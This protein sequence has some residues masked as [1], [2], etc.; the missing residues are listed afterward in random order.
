MKP[1]PTYPVVVSSTD[2]P[3]WS[4]PY[5][6]RSVHDPFHV[7]P[8]FRLPVMPAEWDG[9]RQWLRLAEHRDGSDVLV[10]FG[11]KILTVEDCLP[12]AP[13]QWLRDNILHYFTSTMK[14]TFK[15]KSPGSVFFSSFFLT[16]LF[17]V[18]HANANVE[19]TFSYKNIESWLSKKMKRLKTS[20][21]GSKT[22]AF[23]RNVGRMH[24]ATYVIFQD[25]KIIEEF[26]S[27]GP[28]P[29]GIILKGLYR[30]LFLE[31]KRLGIHLDSSE[32]RL[33]PSR[34]STSRQRNGNDCGVFSILFALHTGLCLNMNNINQ[35]RIPTICCQMLLHILKKPRRSQTERNQTWLPE[36]KRYLSHAWINDDYVTAKAAK[37]DA[38]EVPTTLWDQRILLPLPWATGV[39]RF[40]RTRL[41]AR[42]QRR[43]YCEFR[44]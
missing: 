6:Y 33:Y 29:S 25:L 14:T 22:L 4:G 26:D 10:K 13:M 15:I 27:M 18:G 19:Y 32:W 5:P 34:P 2:L 41:L 16:L 1:E 42:L 39:L 37:S 12:L 17:N 36:L 21:H 30:W 7:L 28:T 8:M 20:L 40:L 31:N 9:Y 43:L 23:F 11:T 38:A 24:W 35:A 44:Q 3:P